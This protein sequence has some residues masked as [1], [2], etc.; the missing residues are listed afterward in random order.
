MS[1]V[2]KVRE[3]F[4]LGPS[5][6]FYSIFNF[7]NFSLP[8]GVMNGWLD[9]SSGSINSTPRDFHAN[10]FRVGAGTGVFGQGQPRTIEFG[11]KVG[12]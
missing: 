5:V 4:S 6:G 10:T 3:R 1:S 8:S 7:A 9:V 2:G 12:F 11:L